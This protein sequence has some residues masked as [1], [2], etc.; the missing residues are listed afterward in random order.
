[1]KKEFVHEANDKGKTKE[2]VLYLW[3]NMEHNELL[4]IFMNLL[5]ELEII[6]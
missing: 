1:V 3:E 5:K 6:G 4:V 2:C